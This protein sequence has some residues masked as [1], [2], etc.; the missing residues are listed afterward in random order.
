MIRPFRSKKHQQRYTLHPVAL[1]GQ[2]LLLRFAR[3]G[4]AEELHELLVAAADRLAADDLDV[5]EARSIVR[6]LTL[7]LTTF[8]ADLERIVEAGTIEELLAVRRGHGHR[9]GDPAARPPRQGPPRRLYPTA[10]RRSRARHRNP[11][12]HV[13]R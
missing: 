12:M 7:L 2:E 10:A 13:T 1:I 3:R 11:M 6:R 4:G 9:S 5:H 8:A